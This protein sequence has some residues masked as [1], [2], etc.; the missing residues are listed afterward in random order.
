MLLSRQK[1]R[2]GGAGL[3]G[4][5]PDVTGEGV[6]RREVDELALRRVQR[7]VE[8]LP[9][10]LTLHTLNG[11]IDIKM[12]RRDMAQLMLKHLRAPFLRQ[13][14]VYIHAEAAVGIRDRHPLDAQ[15]QRDEA[16]VALVNK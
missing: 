4:E 3:H 2:G 8:R 5:T 13:G 6:L 12:L 9:A 11:H 16:D 14:G 1:I 10:G 15:W 7:E